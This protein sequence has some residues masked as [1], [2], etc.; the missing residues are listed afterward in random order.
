M[1]KVFRMKRSPAA[2]IV[3]RAE[4]LQARVSEPDNQDDPAWLQRLA[5]NMQSFALKRCKARQSKLDERRK[6]H[7]P[8]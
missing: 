2:E 8:R 4:K 7:R 1:A 5:K 6:A 3:A